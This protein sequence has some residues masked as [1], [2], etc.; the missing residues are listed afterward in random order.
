VVQL[1]VDVRTVPRSGANPQYYG[2]A[3]PETLSAFQIGFTHIVAL[4]CEDKRGTSRLRSTPAGRTR[5]SQLRRQRMS[6]AFRK[7]HA[8]PAVQR[9]QMPAPTR[10]VP[11]RA[12]H[13]PLALGGRWL[14]ARPH[15]E[16]RRDD[17]EA[18]EG[19]L[20]FELLWAL[21]AAERASN[22][23][24]QERSGRWAVQGD[25]TE[26]AL[27]VAA[28]KAGLRAAV[29]D[30]RFDRIAEV[31]FSSERKL[32]RLLGLPTIG[33]CRARFACSKP[34]AIERAG[35]RYRRAHVC[36][37]RPTH[38]PVA[39]AGGTLAAIVSAAAV[40]GS[41]G[42]LGGIWRLG[43]Q[44]AICISRHLERGGLL[45]WV[46]TWNAA[47]EALAVRVLE[48]HSGQDVHVH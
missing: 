9:V 7:P 26:G 10:G 37:R 15:G 24:L 29:L 2:G 47:K 30:T 5:A 44:H 35:R 34:L 13:K 36:G 33:P 14:V 22:A 48:R 23:A 31:P 40:G 17:G 28:R 11:S 38:G 27:I 1:V 8:V 43:D 6:D 45:F 18:I 20:Q 21:T 4:V 3:L 41:A 46:L 12:L 32:M 42:S 16:M 39:A 19:G 25:P